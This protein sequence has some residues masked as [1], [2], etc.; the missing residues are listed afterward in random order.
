VVTGLYIE[1]SDGRYLEAGTKYG[2][3]VVGVNK[4]LLV[5]FGGPRNEK[6]I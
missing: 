3:R 6:G 2:K 1:L 4:G 5:G